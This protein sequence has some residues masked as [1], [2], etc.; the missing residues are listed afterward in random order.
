M[1]TWDKASLL[2][3]I[4]R[5]RLTWSRRDLDYR[6]PGLTS[7]RFLTAR[8]AARRIADGA[9]VLSCGLAGNARCSTFFWAIREEFE[10]TGHPRGLTWINVGAQGGR[11]KVPGTVEELALPGLV[12]RSITGHHETAKAMLAQADAA[13]LELYTLPQGQMTLLLAAQARGQT[14]LRSRVG[15]NT[16]LDPRTGSGG[17][18]T[19]GSPVVYIQVDADALVYSLPPVQV[20]LFNAPYADAEGNIYFTNAATITENI[21]GAHAARANGGIVFAAVSAIVPTNPDRIGLSAEMVDGVVVNPRNEQTGS[22]P[23][24]RYWPMFTVGAQTDVT[25]SV[26]RLKFAN[27][28]LKITPVRGPV[29]NALARLAA[30]RFVR[31]VPRGSMI[32]IGVGFPEEV[33]RQIFAF[34]LDRDLTFTTETGVYG[35]LPA[36]GIFFGAAINPTRMETSSW[37]FEQYRERL[38]AAVL[39]FLQVDG[40]G[41]VNVSKRGPRMADYVGP[42]GFPDI[43]D[44]ARTVLFVGTWMANA[45]L[46][47]DGG[48]LRVLKPG[49]PKFVARVDEVTL[50]GREALRLGKRIFYVTNVGVFRLMEQGLELIETVPGVDVQRDILDVAGARIQVSPDLAVAE[51]ATLTGMGYTLRWPL[52]AAPATAP[53]S[54]PSGPS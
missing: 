19:P 16:F 11:G 52:A 27:H 32:N 49:Q 10:R 4:I 54:T 51:S 22:V 30:S 43:V 34:G 17:A 7:P 33:V 2:A 5:W 9:N 29:E 6:P 47:V 50:S 12:A 37:M 18:V 31:E 35:G 25:D 23:Q 14:S 3:H 1:N 13:Q 21:Q 40:E 45:A 48:T 15:L 39:G 8:E 28:V 26:A 20:A 36:P 44:S 46:S 24:R 41:N 53:T 42:G 38:G